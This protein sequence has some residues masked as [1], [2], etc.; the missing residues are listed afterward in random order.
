MTRAA[1]RLTIQHKKGMGCEN[2]LSGGMVLGGVGFATSNIFE[3]G[4]LSAKLYSFKHGSLPLC[5]Q[6]TSRRSATHEMAL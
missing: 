1:N 4:A 3:P 2:V 6:I 5:M